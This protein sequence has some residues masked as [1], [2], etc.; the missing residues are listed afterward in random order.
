MA[1][2]RLR[3]HE[4]AK[5]AYSQ[6]ELRQAIELWRMAG[7]LHADWKYSYNLANVL[8]EAGRHIDAWA[9]CDRA[10]ALGLPA[11]H[12]GALAENRAKIAA[13]L[14]R[15]HAW[16]E[17]A[18]TPSDAVVT[19][20]GRPWRGRH[21]AWTEA[22]TSAITV[23][24]V[25]RKT[26][27]FTWE[28]PIGRRHERSVALARAPRFGSLLIQGDP[29]G[30]GIMLD[31]RRVAALPM[32]QPLGELKTGLRTLRVGLRGYRAV[33]RKVVIEAGKITRL[34]IRLAA[35]GADGRVRV[36]VSE[37]G[38]GAPPSWIGVGRWVGLGAGIAA[39]GGGVALLVLA[40][41][42]RAQLEALD[43]DPRAGMADYGAYSTRY[44]ELEAEASSRQGLGLGL[45]ILGGA[46]A[47][48]GA[49]LF[50]LDTDHGGGDPDGVSLLPL[51]LPRGGGLGAV[52]RF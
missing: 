42:S 14:L 48:T 23:A 6:G 17:L 38:S 40:A 9:A 4:R 16:L 45:T 26:E 8:Y 41:D 12:L 52:G 20:D 18:V 51:A 11:K 2:R 39:A 5:A 36:G 21:R 15:T 44:D 27:T 29:K 1:R 47:V 19:R 46:L 24:R 7:E 35:V 31:G 10:E 22:A 30:A 13:E 28:H 49:A 50:A 33:E 43:A 3:L 34:E 32:T 25:G 37:P